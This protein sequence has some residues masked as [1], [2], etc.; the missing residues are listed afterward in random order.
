M[1]EASQARREKLS[2]EHPRY[3]H[4]E[5]LLS[6]EHSLETLSRYVDICEDN[7]KTYSIELSDIILRSCTETEKLCKRITGA[8]AYSEFK[9]FAVPLQTTYPEFATFS[10]EFPLW[11]I[12]TTPWLTLQTKNPV[13]KWWTSYNKIKHDEKKARQSG[14]LY[15]CL[16]AVAGLYVTTLYYDIFVYPLNAKKTGAPR[17][18]IEPW[19]ML[20]CIH[21]DCN[22]VR[23]DRLMWN[24]ATVLDWTPSPATSDANT[25][26]LA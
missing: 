9:A 20:K 15:T 11:N 26:Q 14:S 7:Y 21:P 10:V 2:S 3:R 25:E 23:R 5:V 22:K 19:I 18:V 17:I 12:T 24:D 6:V 4:W 13:P 8:P 1:M 16:H